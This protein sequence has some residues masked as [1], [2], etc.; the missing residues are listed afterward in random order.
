MNA[1]SERSPKSKALKASEARNLLRHEIEKPTREEGEGRGSR[2]VSLPERI[3]D[4]REEAREAYQET[5]HSTLFK[6]LSPQERDTIAGIWAEMG[7]LDSLERVVEKL[8]RGKV[9]KGGRDE[10]ALDML[11]AKLREDAVF[12]EPRARTAMPAAPEAFEAQGFQMA[13]NLELWE[14]PVRTVAEAQ[15][16]FEEMGAAYL[17]A[18]QGRYG[19]EQEEDEALWEARRNLKKALA[20]YYGAL[21]AERPGRKK[22]SEYLG[23]AMEKFESY[24]K[25]PLDLSEAFLEPPPLRA[26][27]TVAWPAAEEKR[28]GKVAVPRQAMPVGAVLLLVAGAFIAGKY[29]EGEPV[30]DA[31]AAEVIQIPAEIPLDDPTTSRDLLPEDP[32]DWERAELPDALPT[33]IDL[34]APARGL[35]PADAE[36]IPEAELRRGRRDGLAADEEERG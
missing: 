5:Y 32:N 9:P 2:L 11:V 16:L 6:R 13:R 22:D 18:E 4:A 7:R 35:E 12:R 3:E 24:M 26:R 31:R 21:C 14:P 25:A 36:D 8:R 20:W 30:E 23:M 19:S 1:R 15:E 17:A 10:K 34:N 29:M 27:P 28:G 33:P